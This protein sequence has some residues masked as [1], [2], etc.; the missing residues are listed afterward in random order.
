MVLLMITNPT[1]T[2]EKTTNSIPRGSNPLKPVGIGL[3]GSVIPATKSTLV[4]I[5]IPTTIN[6]IETGTP[7]I[8]PISSDILESF[9]I[10]F[11]LYLI[12]SFT[13]SITY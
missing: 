11:S 9:C 7:I 10:T 12:F 4:S 3:G 13:S 6:I 8:Q 5:K 2:T 1:M